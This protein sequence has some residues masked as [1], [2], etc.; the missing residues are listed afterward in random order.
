MSDKTDCN[1]KYYRRNNP[2]PIRLGELKPKL[3]ME[4]FETDKSM[5]DVLINIVKDFFE[6]KEVEKSLKGIMEPLSKL[7]P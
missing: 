5:H 2:Y 3:Q 6:R 1:K 7:K 4:A